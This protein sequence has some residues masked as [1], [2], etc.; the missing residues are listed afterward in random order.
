MENKDQN[1]IEPQ[2]G[3]DISVV[4]SQNANERRILY[5]YLISRIC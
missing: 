4:D 3:A 5:E 1:H 2:G